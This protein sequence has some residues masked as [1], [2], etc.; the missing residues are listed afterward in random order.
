MHLKTLLLSIVSFTSVTLATATGW[1]WESAPSGDYVECSV[2]FLPL[3]GA[4]GYYFALETFFT[5]G[6]IGYQGLQFQDEQPNRLVFS[7]FGDGP[8]PYSPQCSGG[9]DGGSGVSCANH[10]VYHVN[11]PQTVTIKLKESFNNGSNVWQGL[12]N[13]L[14]TS[15][16]FVI[17]EYMTPKS[18]GYL[19]GVS[20]GFDEMFTWNGYSG[21]LDKRSCMPK[22]G[23]VQ[24]APTFKKADGTTWTSKYSRMGVHQLLVDKCSPTKDNANVTIA[25]DKSWIKVE[26]GIY[27][28]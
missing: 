3:G 17:A 21:P 22:G 15:E 2:T 6:K 9:A 28:D 20:Y 13:N 7:A 12:F 23:V 11:E 16:P 5:N 24:Y 10:Y 25:D 26:N 19:S 8:V 27:T 14:D 18:Y 1:S 4:Y